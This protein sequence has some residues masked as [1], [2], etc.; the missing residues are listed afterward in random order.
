MTWDYERGSEQESEGAESEEDGDSAFM[1]FWSS[2]TQ[3]L[4]EPAELARGQNLH[5]APT[6]DGSNYLFG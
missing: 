4:P 6:F 5:H 1:A 2:F 3:T